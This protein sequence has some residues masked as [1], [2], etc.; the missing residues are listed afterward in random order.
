MADEV[1]AEPSELV[2]LA[3]TTLD[4]SIALGDGWRAAQPAFSVPEAAFGILSAG[5]GVHRSHVAAAE[6]GDTAVNRLV[7]VYEGD[8]DRL[9]R[10]AFAYQQADQEAAARARRAGGRPGRAVI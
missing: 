1:R 4:A 8:V 3:G 10:V 5:Q 9:Y 7:A 6:D 2:K